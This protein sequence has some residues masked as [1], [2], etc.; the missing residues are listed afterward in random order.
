MKFSKT[1]L[2]AIAAGV[3]MTSSASYAEIELGQGLSVTGFIDM[4]FVYTDVDGAA[5]TDKVF[6]VDQVETNFMYKGSDGVSA[7]VDIEYG[8][9]GDDSGADETFVEQAFITKQ[10]TDDF[11]VKAGR[12]LS[13]SGWETEEPTGLFQYSGTGYGGVFYGFYQQGVSGMYSFGDVGAVTLSVVNDV[14]A[15]PIEND[16]TQ[17]GTELGIHLT[18]VEGLT[19]KAFYMTEGDKEA[20]NLWASY[21]IEDL[22]LAVELNT[23]EDTTGVD[24]ESDGYLFMANYAIG[25]FGITLRYHAYETEDSVGATITDMS[26]ITIAPSYAV[27]DN[28]LFVAEYRMDTDDV[29]DV[30]TDT[31]ALEALYTF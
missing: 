11:S 30:D 21:A 26:G 10:V 31:F 1:K 19:A 6:G 3:L 18:P 7:Q 27:G 20:L 12:F 17:L 29:S 28:L 15:N 24:E 5:S 22:T 4:S 9:S 25:D 23:A 13:Y 14:F 8:E 2:S 16:T